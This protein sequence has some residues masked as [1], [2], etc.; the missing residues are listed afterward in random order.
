MET[1]Q[2]SALARITDGLSVIFP[3]EE[4]FFQSYG[5]NARYVGHPFL[6]PKSPLCLSGGLAA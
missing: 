4:P 5:V 6:E 2:A 3:F 1:I